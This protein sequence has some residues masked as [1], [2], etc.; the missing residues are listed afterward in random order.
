MTLEEITLALKSADAPPT[1]ALRA[2]LAKADQLAPVIFTLVDKLCVGIYLL[3]E[4]S[5]LLH[6]GLTILAAAKHAGLLPYL[7]KLSRQRQEELEQVFPL[8]IPNSLTR[9]LL[10]VWDSNGDA[11]FQAIEDEELIPEVRWAWFDVL[12]RLTFDG[13]I[14]RECTL[15]FLARLESDGA[16]DD[17]DSAW[18]GWEEAVIRLGATELEPVLEQVWSKVIFDEH[19]D[20]EHAESLEELHRAASDPADPAIFDEN[21]IRPIGD[22][23]EAVAWIERRIEAIET[24]EPE[25][26][27]PDNDPAKAIRLAGDEIDWLSGFLVSRQAPESAMSFEALDGFFTAL[28]IGPELVMPSVYLPE[29]WG[30]AD[31]TGPLWDS[32]EQLRY[33]MRLITKHWNAVAARKNANAPHMLQIDF[34]GEEA[35]GKAWA[36]GFIAGMN[37]CAQAWDAL[38]DNDR[39]GDI[40]AQ[41]RALAT[42]GEFLEDSTRAAIVDDLP[43]I[44][45]IIAAYWASPAAFP[46]R[47]VPLRSKKTGRNEPCPCGSGKKYKKCCGLNSEPTLH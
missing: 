13:I 1:N 23:V 15:A 12:A 9:L 42:E 32:E 43:D 22:P 34:F 37:L 24:W 36:R 41:I 31:G 46:A 25:K 35:L 18:W 44:V 40:A 45:R 4:E 17:G 33:F 8:H 7:L 29:I 39:V 11:I 10:S 3:P 20:E 38:M 47:N 28:A 19:T 5:E 21:E 30:T 26:G 2:G 27:R 14:S 16:I 6:Y